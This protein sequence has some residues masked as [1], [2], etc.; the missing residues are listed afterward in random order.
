MAPLCLI[1]WVIQRRSYLP[2]RGLFCFVFSNEWNYAALITQEQR[3]TKSTAVLFYQK[4]ILW[5]FHSSKLKRKHIQE[6]LSWILYLK[7][8]GDRL[9]D[10]DTINRLI[11]RKAN[12]YNFWFLSFMFLFFLVFFTIHVSFSLCRIYTFLTL[13]FRKQDTMSLISCSS[14]PLSIILSVNL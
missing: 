10:R 11:L 14:C 4:W 7:I 6:A 8:S 1:L 9:P 2:L 3:N 12:L 5:T 13:L